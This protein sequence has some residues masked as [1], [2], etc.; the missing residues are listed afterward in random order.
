MRRRNRRCE[1]WLVSIT[2]RKQLEIQCRGN[3]GLHVAVHCR[4]LLRNHLTRY[5]LSPS[6]L[7]IFASA[8]SLLTRRLLLVAT[9]LTLH[10]LA[11][12]LCLVW[13]RMRILNE[14]F[15]VCGVPC[16]FRNSDLLLVYILG[17]QRCQGGCQCLC[18]LERC[19]SADVWRPSAATIQGRNRSLHRNQNIVELIILLWSLDL[20]NSAV[21][22]VLH[23]R[24][25]LFLFWGFL[26]WDTIFLPWLL[27]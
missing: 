8:L 3:W 7:Q 10:R 19:W 15:W 13:C 25:G 2:R 22:W 4:L 6:L 26:V 1:S 23:S 12:V 21:P 24:I 14:T 16:R 9:I 17:L 20:G 11:L 5:T 27:V 18:R